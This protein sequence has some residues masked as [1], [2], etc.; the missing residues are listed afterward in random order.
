MFSIT[1][2]AAQQIKQ[3]ADASGASEMALRIAAKVDTDGSLQ[4]GMGFDEPKDEDMKLDL[5]G[6]AG[7]RVAIA[8]AT[9][10]LNFP[11]AA[12]VLVTVKVLSTAAPEAE[13]AET[14]AVI[15]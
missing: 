14:L 13:L 11:R 5:K 8:A 3:A 15:V 9:L 2:A 12:S 6:V 7:S 10:I 4:Y 1:S